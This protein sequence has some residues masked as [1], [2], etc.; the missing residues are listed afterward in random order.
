MELAYKLTLEEHGGILRCRGRLENSDL[1]VDSQP[2]IILM[3]DRKLTKLLIEECHKKVHHGGVRATLGELRS[4]FWVPKGRQVVKR[5]LRKRDL[6]KDKQGKPF[7]A[8]P[9]VVLP[10]FRVKEATP[11]SRVGIDFARPLFLKA[12]TGEMV[13]KYVVL[14]TCCVP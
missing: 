12:H 8:P 14:F 1:D 6:E 13:K 3:K 10:D 5:V 4:Q 7:R 9:T 11:F 2:P